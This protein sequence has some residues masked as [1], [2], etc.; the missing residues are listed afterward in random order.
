LLKHGQAHQ[1][2]LALTTKFVK[3]LTETVQKPWQPSSQIDKN[4]ARRSTNTPKSTQTP[5]KRMAQ[6]GQKHWGVA[7]TAHRARVPGA[8]LA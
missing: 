7:V 2:T 6:T 8:L 5:D 4:M 3:L 1:K